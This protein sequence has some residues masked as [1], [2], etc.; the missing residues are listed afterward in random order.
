MKS[1]PNWISYPTNFSSLPGYFSRASNQFQSY[2]KLKK[3][4]TCGALRSVAL[5]PRAAPW[6]AAVGGAV[7]TCATRVFRRRLPCPKSRRRRSRVRSRPSPRLTRRP[8]SPGLTPRPPR[9]RFDRHVRALHR[10]HGPKPRAA[11]ARVSH[12]AVVSS[13]RAGR[14]SPLSSSS[15][16]RRSAVSHR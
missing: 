15:A 11:A 6:L 2:L 8:D 7:R 12:C 1:V 3:T 10:C 14:C 5:S 13:R 4:L 9:S 16:G